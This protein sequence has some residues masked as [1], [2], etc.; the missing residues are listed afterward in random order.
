M[1]Q[2]VTSQKQ[3][4]HSPP[5]DSHDDVGNGGITDNSCCPVKDNLEDFDDH[6]AFATMEYNTAPFIKQVIGMANPPIIDSHEFGN[7]NSVSYFSAKISRNHFG[8]YKLVSHLQFSIRCDAPKLAHKNVVTQLKIT[9][10]I[11]GMTCKQQIQLTNVMN[12]ALSTEP[13]DDYYILCAFPFSHAMIFTL[14]RW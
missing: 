4:I 14:Y 7:V 5:T 6:H 1:D 3:P 8:V 12:D 2:K 13:I 10:L 9:E 11:L